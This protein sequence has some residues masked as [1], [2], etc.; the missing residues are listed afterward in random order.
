MATILGGKDDAQAEFT[1]TYDQAY[2]AASELLGSLGTLKVTDR[3]GGVLKADLPSAGV[4][5]EF[6]RV[7][8]ATTRVSVSARK[9]MLPKKDVA[10]GILY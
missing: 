3:A 7:S 4:T 8:P 1:V 10:Q 9:Y 2:Q 5:V 6:E